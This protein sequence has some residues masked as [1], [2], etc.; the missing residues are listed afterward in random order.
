MNFLEKNLEDIVFETPNDKLHERGFFLF[1][2]KKRQVRIGNYGIA[3][4]ITYF[5]RE[6]KMFI[7]VLE[8][9]KDKVS[10]ETLLQAV[11]Y[12]KGIKRYLDRRA[13]SFDISIRITLIGKEVDNSNSFCYFPDIFNNIDVFTYEY[14][15]DGIFFH[16]ETGFKLTNEGFGLN[17]NAS[18]VNIKDSEPF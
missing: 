14:Q 6:N 2:E 17:K 5:R 4:I 1:G 13:C 7:N 10:I 16:Q 15:F 12:V 8:L 9:K 11:N 18:T 3:D